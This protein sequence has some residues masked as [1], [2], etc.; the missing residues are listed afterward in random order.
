MVIRGEKVYYQRLEGE[1]KSWIKTKP[2]QAY[3]CDMPLNRPVSLSIEFEIRKKMFLKPYFVINLYLNDI[4]VNNIEIEMP[5][6]NCRDFSMELLK[7]F[8]GCVSSVMLLS[9]NLAG[10]IE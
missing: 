1:S 5:H 2:A 10:L 3:L 8:N 4:T 9:K 6:F 7:N